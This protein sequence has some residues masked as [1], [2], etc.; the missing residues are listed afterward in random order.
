MENILTEQE[1]QEFRKKAKLEVIK[2]IESFGEKITDYEEVFYNKN[3]N[4]G[5]NAVDFLEDLAFDILTKNN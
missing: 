3:K 2:F 1:E 4:I 5:F